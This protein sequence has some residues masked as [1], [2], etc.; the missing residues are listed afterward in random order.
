MQ[1]LNEYK[2]K[3]Q[4]QN[5]Y[6]EASR[7]QE[8]FA[9]SPCSSIGGAGRQQYE[10]HIAVQDVL[11]KIDAMNRMFE[12][13]IKDGSAQESGSKIMSIIN[14][15]YDLA[16]LKMAEAKKQSQDYMQKAAGIPAEEPVPEIEAPPVEDRPV[17]SPPEVEPDSE[18]IDS[19]DS[20]ADDAMFDKYSPSEEEPEISSDSDESPGEIESITVV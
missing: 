16:G 6:K 1:N 9:L 2:Q 7:I 3:R 19:P 17:E 15:L 8:A 18:E 10:G 13:C 5:S 4:I 12:S 11:S 14:N 20:T